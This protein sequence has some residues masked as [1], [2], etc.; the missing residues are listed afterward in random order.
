[1]FL[2]DGAGFRISNFRAQVSEFEF[3]SLEGRFDARALYKW[4]EGPLCAHSNS[5]S[6]PAAAI[7]VDSAASSRLERG[8]EGTTA[9]TVAPAPRAIRRASEMANSDGRVGAPLRRSV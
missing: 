4:G 2:W 1:M 5:L 9:Y 3:Q 7:G 6:A 8:G